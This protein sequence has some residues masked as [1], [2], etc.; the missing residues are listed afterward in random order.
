MLRLTC[1]TWIFIC[2]VQCLTP[3]FPI[4]SL[5]GTI[6]WSFEMRFRTPEVQHRSLALWSGGNRVSTVTSVQIFLKH[7]FCS[8]MDHRYRY[9]SRATIIWIRKPNH[10]SETHV[11]IV[12]FIPRRGQICVYWKNWGSRSRPCVKKVAKKWMLPFQAWNFLP[13]ASYATKI[14]CKPSARE[15]QYYIT[16]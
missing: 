6:P 8:P 12:P 10:Y 5:I 1:Q 13:K 15:S 3:A 4:F 2:S 16:Y 11:P 9:C 14:N 7:G